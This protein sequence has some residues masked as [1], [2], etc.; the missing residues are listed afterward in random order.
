LCWTP[1]WYFVSLICDRICNNRR[2]AILEKVESSVNKSTC[3]TNLWNSEAI[4]YV[5][6]LKEPWCKICLESQYCGKNNCRKHQNFRNL[7]QNFC[8]MFGHIFWLENI[9]MQKE[10]GYQWKHYQ[11][12]QWSP[13]DVNLLFKTHKIR[14]RK[15]F[16][17]TI[18]TRLQ[19]WYNI[20]LLWSWI[21]WIKVRWVSC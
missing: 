13:L 4:R 15:L 7:K 8:P 10:A 21:E 2:F 19:S 5:S 14:S 17:T 11:T 3:E 16:S 12:Y 18:K 6:L 9:S 20:F 1:L